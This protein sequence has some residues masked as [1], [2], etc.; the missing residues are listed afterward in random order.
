[1]IGADE[2]ESFEDFARK[3]EGVLDLMRVDSGVESLEWSSHIN[4]TKYVEKIALTMV[5]DAT[6]IYVATNYCPFMWDY[7]LIPV[8]TR[9]QVIIDGLD[10]DQQFEK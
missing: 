2:F 9:T 6:P 5:E 8:F 7:A 1:V 10:D 3:M 4:C